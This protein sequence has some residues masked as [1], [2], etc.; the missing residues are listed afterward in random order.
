MRGA[1]RQV[2]YHNFQHAIS[3]VHYCYKLF[4][5]AG[6]TDHMEAADMFAC[7]IGGLCHDCDHRGFNNHFE[8][9]TRSELALRYNDSSPLENHHCAMSFE[10]ARDSTCNIFQRFSSDAYMTVRKRMIAG[11]LSTDMKHHGDHI[12]LISSFNLQDGVEP[13]QSQFLVEFFLHTADIGNPIM[14]QDISRRMSECVAEEFNLQAEQERKLGLPVTAFMVGLKT[15]AAR[16]KSQLGFMDFVVA[17]LL[18]P[19]LRVFP[20]LVQPKKHFY[21]NRETLVVSLEGEVPT[22]ENGRQ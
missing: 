17:P 12:R 22:G 3:V 9:M 11:I 2:P 6:M 16:A 21:D 15:P 19:M 8:V 20:A 14:P 13:E 5:A 18:E 7:I 1:Y 10:I 4:H